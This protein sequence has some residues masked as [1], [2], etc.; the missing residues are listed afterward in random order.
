MDKEDFK[1]RTKQY[2]LRIINLLMVLA[3]VVVGRVIGN[4]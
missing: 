4:Q 2:A 3:R 1:K